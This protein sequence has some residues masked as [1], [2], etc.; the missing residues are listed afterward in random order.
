MKVYATSDQHFTHYN[1]IKY[2]QRPFE[3]STKGVNDCIE[4][5]VNNYNQIVTDEDVVIFVGDLAHGRNCN[6]QMLSDIINSM[7]GKKILVKGNHDTFSDSFYRTLFVDVKE[8]I[9]IGK[10]F[11]SH[12][13]CYKSKWMLTETEKKHTEI[14]D[15][16]KCSVVIHGHIHNKNPN[17]WAPDG[18][19]R[20][21]V[22]VDYVLNE[23]KPV[24]LKDPVI[25]DYFSQYK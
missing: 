8:Y 2:A 23:F 4:T 13:P 21:N 22:S 7:K 6:E 11:I 15:T 17:L 10:Y 25:V 20:I 24:E 3:L 9:E 14:I 18:I 16:D 12:Y 19:Y 1:I 5:I